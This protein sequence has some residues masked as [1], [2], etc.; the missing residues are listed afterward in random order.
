[1]P[2]HQLSW[3][4][5][6][7]LKKTSLFE[8]KMKRKYGGTLYC[9][10]LPGQHVSKHLKHEGILNNIY[11]HNQGPEKMLK[12]VADFKA[13]VH[14]AAYNSIN[15]TITFGFTHKNLM[16]KWIGKT[17]PFRD[18]PLVLKEF[19]GRRLH[20][21]ASPKDK[22]TNLTVAP[23]TLNYRFQIGNVDS[24]FEKW[25]I[26]FLA[27]YILNLNVSS[28]YRSIKERTGK[29]DMSSWTIV[30]KDE[31]CPSNLKGKTC[32]KW[33]DSYMYIYHHTVYKGIPCSRCFSPHHFYHKCNTPEKY[34]ENEGKIY[35]LKEKEVVFK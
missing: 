29:T 28:I 12:M 6:G 5:Y 19:N 10:L 25:D 3:N 1:M 18:E 33:A 30:L 2:K 13:Q 8:L 9:T 11:R 22:P 32:F 14:T 17:I 34:C 7:Q 35:M 27:Q 26:M 16:D 21:C 24:I 23:T 20:Q 15:R 31:E 4:K